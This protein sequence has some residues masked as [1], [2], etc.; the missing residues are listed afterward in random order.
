[1]PH[2]LGTRRKLTENATAS[3]PVLSMF[4][5]VVGSLGA[6]TRYAER[7]SALCSNGRAASRS[8]TRAWPG[9]RTAFGSQ[10][11]GWADAKPPKSSIASRHPGRLKDLA[12]VEETLHETAVNFFRLERRRWREADD[13][14]FLLDI[15][16][17]D[18]LGHRGFDLGYNR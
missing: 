1:M 7:L 9:T 3:G 13:D 15:D 12:S 17:V 6:S 8:G 2:R 4:G 16:G 5:S 18:R 14:V 11:S 10:N